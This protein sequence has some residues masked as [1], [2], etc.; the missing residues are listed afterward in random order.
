MFVLVRHAH[1]GEKKSWHGPD[2]DRPLNTL[3]VLA[4]RDLVAA[5]VRP[6]HCSTFRPPHPIDRPN[7]A[8]PSGVTVFAR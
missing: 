6:R 3:G 8:L 2:A 1:T 7:A 4:T 5:T